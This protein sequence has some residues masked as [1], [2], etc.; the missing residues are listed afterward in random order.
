MRISVVVAQGLGCS[1][2]REIFLD[3][4]LNT[5]PLHWHA[6]SYPLHHLGSP[7]V[8]KPATFMCQGC[9]S[10]SKTLFSYLFLGVLSLGCSVG[11][12]L[13][14]VSRATFPCSVRAS[15]CGGFSCGARALGL[16]G[17][18]DWDV[19]APSLGFLGLVVPRYV[20]SS[21]T[22]DW[23]CG[24]CNGRRTLNTEPCESLLNKGFLQAT[25]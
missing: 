8:A 18:H 4:G 21:W 13:V 24:S 1:T 19:W 20:G 9:E 16:S 17:F 14:V 5:C 10:H 7:V 25:F 15:H 12:S 6:D 23:T 22:R 2:A 3:Q 11:F